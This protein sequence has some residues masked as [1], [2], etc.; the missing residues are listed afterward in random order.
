MNGDN[1]RI[2]T[3]TSIW[4]ELEKV[5]PE[6]DHLVVYLGTNGSEKA[7][8]LAAQHVPAE[9]VTF[10]G[11][12]CNLSHKEMMIQR[13]GLQNCGRLLCECGGHDTMKALYRVYM[14]KG[15]AVFDQPVAV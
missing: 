7:I 10:V 8:E 11:C 9:K 1:N 5:L 2:D 15:H 4:S 13:A 6:L 12:D 3:I 14:E